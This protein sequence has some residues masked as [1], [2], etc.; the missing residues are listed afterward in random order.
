MIHLSGIGLSQADDMPRS[1]ILRAFLLGSKLSG[2]LFIVCTVI[3][4][5]N[6]Y[7][8]GYALL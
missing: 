3:N 5:V 8:M 2:I 6:G 7:A 1:W 4:A